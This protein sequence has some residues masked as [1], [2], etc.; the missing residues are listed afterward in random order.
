MS[1][2]QPSKK[3]ISFIFLALKKPRLRGEGEV[4]LVIQKIKFIISKTILKDKVAILDELMG[5]QNHLKRGV[6]VGQNSRIKT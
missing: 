2:S 4:R 6:M 1:I 5:D 3:K